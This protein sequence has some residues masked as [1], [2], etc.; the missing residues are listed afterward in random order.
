MASQRAFMQYSSWLDSLT[1][2]QFNYLCGFTQCSGN[3]LINKTSSFVC[4]RI[5]ILKS[6]RFIFLQHSLSINLSILA[7]Y[8]QLMIIFNFMPWTMVSV[9]GLFAKLFRFE[10]ITVK[11]THTH[12]NLIGFISSQAVVFFLFFFFFFYELS[13]SVFMWLLAQQHC[14]ADSME[15]RFISVS[16]L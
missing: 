2:R 7:M 16:W 12:T 4:R 1:M 10:P 13:Y 11:H 6:I 9:Y 5:S 15:Y 3:I 14:F 8:L